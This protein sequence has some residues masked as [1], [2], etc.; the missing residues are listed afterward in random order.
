M[1]LKP[2]IFKFSIALSNVDHN[3]YLDLNLTV[4][5]HPSETAERMMT[6]VL[7][8]CLNAS[9]DL[10]FARGLSASDEPDIWQRSLDG[11]ILKWIE[12]GE[13]VAERLRKASHIAEEVKVYCFNTKSDLWWARSEKEVTAAKVQAIQFD[14]G[15]IVELSGLLARTL[16]LSITVTDQS[17][18][19]ASDAGSVEVHWR[20]LNA[21]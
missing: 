20:L 11:R 15:Q 9:E 2:T 16:Q 6:R 12:I 10:E 1:A 21:P 18:F 4:A 3:Q 5:Q 8:Y 7:A 17:A 13:P 14:W 19:I